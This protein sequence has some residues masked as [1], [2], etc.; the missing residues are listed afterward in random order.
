MTATTHPV[1]PADRRSSTPRLD[2]ADQPVSAAPLSRSSKLGQVL[3]G[4]TRISLGW[5]FLW[6]FLD[7]AFGLGYA[8]TSKDAWI[9]G[10]SP[11]FGFLSFGAAGPFK[12]AYHSIAGDAW[13][14]WLFMIGLLSIGIA[15][16]LGVFM[17][18]AAAAGALL[19]LLMWTA[20][21]PP[22]NNPVMDDHIVYALTL[23]L[24]ACLGA[25]RWL[26]LGHMW[27]RTPLV[28]KSA[29]LR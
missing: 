21:L 4:L 16:I 7:K 28:Q 9:D 2:A 6:A 3:G 24:L 14:D 15:L 22:E 18:I 1:Q 8:T 5:V 25:G 13:A 19:L 29:L 20:V 11:T 27:E 17:N 26:G 12:G 10:G 23:G